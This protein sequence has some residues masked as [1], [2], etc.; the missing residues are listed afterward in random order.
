MPRPCV[1][2]DS[3][4]AQPGCPVC[5]YWSEFPEYYALYEGITLVNSIPEEVAELRRQ[6]N[7]ALWRSADAVR[8]VA[9]KAGRPMPIA[10]EQGEGPS[11]LRKAI[12][13]GKAVAGH[14]AHGLPQAEPELR[15]KRRALCVLCDEFLPSKACRKCG[16]NV[17]LK[18][19]WAGESCPLGKW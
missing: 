9:E 16:C 14:V 15:D 5:R 7:N 13:F 2:A 19:A 18:T 11:L 4:H 10:I 1:H 8:E 3:L 12:N 17:E 6:G